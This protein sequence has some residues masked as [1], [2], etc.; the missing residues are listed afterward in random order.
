MD[1]GLPGPDAH[2]DA[3]CEAV[4]GYLR[5]H[6]HGMETLEG[7]A[8]WWIPR[9]QVRVELESLGRVLQRLERLGLIEGLQ[10]GDG[11][12]YRLKSPDVQT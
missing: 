10:L 3:L 9:R 1:G 4:L 7:I 2:D 6:P 11:R 5:E 8:E 12:L